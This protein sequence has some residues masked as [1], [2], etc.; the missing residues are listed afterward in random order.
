MPEKHD[1]ALRV[2][3]IRS[4][5]AI[6][7]TMRPQLQGVRLINLHHLGERVREAQAAS[8]RTTQLDDELQRRSLGMG[9]LEGRV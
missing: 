6:T 4:H 9:L 7:A 1:P 8:G 5:S 3:D 2:L